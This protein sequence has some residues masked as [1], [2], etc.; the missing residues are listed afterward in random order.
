MINMIAHVLR[1]LFLSILTDNTDIS[2][3]FE[4]VAV[5]ALFVINLMVRHIMVLHCGTFDS[6]TST[7]FDCAAGL[8]AVLGK[9][10]HTAERIDG[11]L[12]ILMVAASQMRHLDGVHEVCTPHELIVIIVLILITHEL[13]KLR[14]IL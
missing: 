4:E 7:L 5:I 10:I 1:L 11:N 12:L 13:G 9:A 2:I 6:F 14:I 3:A 8:A